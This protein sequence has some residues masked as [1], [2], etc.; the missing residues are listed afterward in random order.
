[1]LIE[2]LN[3]SAI[4]FES[5]LLQHAK[6]CLLHCYALLLL[7]SKFWKQMVTCLQI[8]KCWFL[9][10]NLALEGK[11]PHGYM[12]LEGSGTG[13]LK[14]IISSSSDECKDACSTTDDCL[15][16]DYN[17]DNNDCWLNSNFGPSNITSIENQV[18][19]SKLCKW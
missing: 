3:K 16:Y 1:M 4:I 9:Y 14:K 13:S 19:C 6:S 15:G 17:S 11:C 18:F 8:L 5:L 12:F 7:F 10:W 2:T